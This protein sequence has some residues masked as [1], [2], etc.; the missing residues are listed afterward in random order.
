MAYIAFAG[1]N[2]AA[3]AVY[4][5]PEAVIAPMDPVS[6]AEFLYHDKLKGA[7][8]L[9]AARAQNMPRMKALHL[10]QQPRVRLTKW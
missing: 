2:V 1:R 5:L 4:A 3:D 10:R 9:A 8:D 6:A 7:D